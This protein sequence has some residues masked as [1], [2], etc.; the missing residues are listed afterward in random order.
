MPRFTVP[1]VAHC[2]SGAADG[3][4]PSKVPDTRDV[5]LGDL[6]DDD[7]PSFGSSI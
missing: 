2:E 4:V 3:P 1:R 7:G 5:P 6:A